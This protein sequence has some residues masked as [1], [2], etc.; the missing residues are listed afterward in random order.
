[1]LTSSKS[2]ET[3]AIDLSGRVESFLNKV[4]V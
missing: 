4:A 3:A 2:V 1:V